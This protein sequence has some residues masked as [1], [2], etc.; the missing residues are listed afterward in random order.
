MLS[1]ILKKQYKE[2]KQCCLTYGSQLAAA[3]KQWSGQPVLP[4]SPTLAPFLL[5]L[6]PNALL[7]PGDSS[8]KIPV[9][10]LCREMF[11]ILFVNF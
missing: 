7:V 3:T 2:T 1:Q 8:K 6:R 4:P 9:L 10:L 11:T 5:T